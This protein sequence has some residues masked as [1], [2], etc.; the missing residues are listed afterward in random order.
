M[1]LGKKF[2]LKFI[3]LGFLMTSGYRSGT[4]LDDIQLLFLVFLSPPRALG[5]FLSQA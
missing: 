4:M 2:K 5:S 3:A 1:S